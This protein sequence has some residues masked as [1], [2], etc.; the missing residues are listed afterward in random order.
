[1]QKDL[2]HQL[3]CKVS[4]EGHQLY[5]WWGSPRKL[6]DL[7]RVDFVEAIEEAGAS[8]MCTLLRVHM[9]EKL[10]ETFVSRT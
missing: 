10:G 5:C 6:L 1:M 3:L 4:K 2:E 7:V 9:L 8:H